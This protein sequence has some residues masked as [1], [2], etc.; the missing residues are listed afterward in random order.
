MRVFCAVLM[1][2]PMLAH[3]WNRD[4]AFR[5]LE[6]RQQRWSDWK[7]AQKTGGP[8]L[9]CHTGLPYLFARHA[10]RDKQARPLEG[11]LGEG[12]K[13]RLLANPPE[14]QGGSAS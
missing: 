1:L 4:G 13:T 8:C 10:L 2:A 12:V 11:A 7:P 6:D 14:L 9:S 5:Y 3:G